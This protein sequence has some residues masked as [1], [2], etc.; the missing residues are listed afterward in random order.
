MK[1]ITFFIQAWTKLAFFSEKI[2][3][4]F[5]MC[6]IEIKYFLNTLGYICIWTENGFSF[7]KFAMCTLNSYTT[8]AK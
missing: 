6:T 1:H 8:Q 4:R 3:N 2:S 5:V 7:C